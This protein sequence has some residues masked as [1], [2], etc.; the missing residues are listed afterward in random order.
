MGPD[1]CYFYNSWQCRDLVFL[2]AESVL[3]KARI[4]R[5]AENPI[6]PCPL[7]VSGA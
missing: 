3:V 2:V 4:L 7:V 1:R 6:P 5:D